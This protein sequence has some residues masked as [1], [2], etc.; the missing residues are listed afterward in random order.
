VDV[1]RRPGSGQVIIVAGVLVT[2]RLHDGKVAR[3]P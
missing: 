3:V 1:H 2:H